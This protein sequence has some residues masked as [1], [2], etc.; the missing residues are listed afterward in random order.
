MNN[1][2]WILHVIGVIYLFQFVDFWGEEKK[3]TIKSLEENL[4]LDISVV[5]FLFWWIDGAVNEDF[6]R[7]GELRGGDEF[8]IRR[9]QVPY[10]T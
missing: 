10:V 3:K 8:E 7:I 4:I 9:N 1:N 5:W 6:L 2:V